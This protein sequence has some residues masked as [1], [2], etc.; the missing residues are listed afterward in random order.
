MRGRTPFE[1]HTQQALVQG[2][3]RILQGTQADAAK[4]RL[5]VALAASALCCAPA[6]AG[7]QAWQPP[8]GIP[9]PSFGVTESAPAPTNTLSGTLPTSLTLV[10]GKVVEIAPGAYVGSMTISGR[11]TVSKPCFV[12]GTS[13]SSKPKINGV[14]TVR[15]A[16]YVV[17]ENLQFEDVS[18]VAV[19]IIGASDHV[20]FRRSVLQNMP[21]PGSGGCGGI[22][23]Q[24]NLG[25]HMTDIVVYRN[26]FSNLGMNRATWNTKDEDFHGVV[27]TLWGRDATTELERVWILENECSGLSGNCVQVNAGNW[28][29]SYRYLHHVY[30]GRNVAFDNRQGGFASKQARDVIISQNTV[31]QGRLYAG[32]GGDGIVFQYGPDNL[33]IIFNHLY[34]VVFGVRQSDTPVGV[35]AHNAYVIGNV[36]HDS[37]QDPN[38]E[39][40]WGSPPGWA[41]SLWSGGMSRWIVDNTFYRVHGGVESIF[42]EPVSVSGNIISER[43]P[44]TSGRP[45]AYHVFIEHPARNGVASMDRTLVYQP[46]SSARLRWGFQGIMTGLTAFQSATGQCINCVEA[47][48]LFA[49]G[50]T[51]DL[52][53]AANSPARGRGVRHPA[54]DV[55]FA[56]YGIDIAKGADGGARPLSGAWDLGAYQY[57]V[58]NGS[59]PAAPTGLRIIR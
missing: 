13:E 29:N 37:Y 15:D 54:Y 6:F 45:D 8:I 52:R 23:I 59:Q 31:Y 19:N 34:D 35:E 43:L 56:L 47:D 25:A 9:A 17:L 32:Q 38:V 26:R 39:T 3:A 33:W 57:G 41:I 5:V 42:G 55:F 48:P 30:I 12:R 53:L 7:A 2:W 18:C 10:P 36:I 49:N 4:R 50:A 46:G 1:R 20:S 51:R 40:H 27:P 24:P 58:S 16:S 14:F 28:S 21:Y 44:P 22:G 11:C